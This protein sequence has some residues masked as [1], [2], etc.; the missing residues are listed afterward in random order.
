MKAQQMLE[1][2]SCTN[3]HKQKHISFNSSRTSKIPPHPEIQYIFKESEKKRRLNCQITLISWLCHI[4]RRGDRNHWGSEVG[5]SLSKTCLSAL[6]LDLRNLYG[7]FR[8]SVL[9]FYWF[10]F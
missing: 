9:L 1:R 2:K 5:L 7:F 8:L 4:Y 10:S 6:S 3:T